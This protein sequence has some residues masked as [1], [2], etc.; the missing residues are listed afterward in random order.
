[1]I[2]HN[3]FSDIQL[4]FSWLS[5]PLLQPS[6]RII[7]F[8]RDKLCGLESFDTISGHSNF[9]FHEAQNSAS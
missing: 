2:I 7:S 3:I 9:W 6:I 8:P 5:L 1:L 4:I